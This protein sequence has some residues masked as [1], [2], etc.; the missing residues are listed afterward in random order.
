MARPTNLEQNA[1]GTDGENGDG[2]SVQAGDK[3]ETSSLEASGKGT[4]SVSSKF[5]DGTRHSPPPPR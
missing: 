5:L 1:G 4:D 3:Y 2:L